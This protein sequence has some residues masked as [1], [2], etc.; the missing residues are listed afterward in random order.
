[1]RRRKGFTLIEL[2]V[3][4]A[5][6]AILAAILFP[7]FAKARAKARQSACLSNLKQIGLAFAQYNSDHDG[8]YPLGTPGCVAMDTA[9]MLPWWV[10]IQPYM[11]NAGILEC[12]S[13][14][15]DFI[16]NAGWCGNPNNLCTRRAPGQKGLSYGHSIA[17]SMNHQNNGN[18]SCCA[19][20]GGKED[21]LLAPAESFLVADSGR[22]DIG[23]GL[24]AG[25]AACAGSFSDGICAPIVMANH[26][27]NCAHG[28]CGFGGTFAQ[29]LQML[30]TTSD[31]CAR[32]NGGGNILFADGHTK[33]FK[34]E[35][36]RGKM[37]GGP[38][39]FNGAELYQLP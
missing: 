38:I 5:I 19:S 7:V 6:I 32:H 31:A 27:A 10:A 16:N 37:V 18:R 14:N 26:L 28:V 36:T 3:V 1:M 15:T 8:I 2:L 39:R 4:I 9:F 29:R 20:T 12:P 33:W 11:K 21:A 25:G 35:A 13:A 17:I 23:G 24:W 30:G 34:S 22:A